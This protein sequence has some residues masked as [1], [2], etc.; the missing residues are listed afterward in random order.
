MNPETLTILVLAGVGF[1][2]L[3]QHYLPFEAISRYLWCSSNGKPNE[4]PP[5]SSES[6]ATDEPIAQNGNPVSST[7]V[8][9]PDL[10]LSPPV[11]RSEP[12]YG[13]TVPQAKICA[14]DLTDL[15]SQQEEEI[16][17]GPCSAPPSSNEHRT[18]VPLSSRVSP[19]VLDDE[20]GLLVQSL[21]SFSHTPFRGTSETPSPIPT[22]P[23]PHA[24]FNSSITDLVPIARQLHPIILNADR[25]G[26][27]SVTNV[28]PALNLKP[29]TV[30]NAPLGHAPPVA[31]PIPLVSPQA[32]NSLPDDRAV[33]PWINFPS[34]S[35]ESTL[36][37][38]TPVVERPFA[39][40]PSGGRSA[41][42]GPNFSSYGTSL[43]QPS[44]FRM[45]GRTHGGTPTSFLLHSVRLAASASS[46][47]G[48]SGSP[49]L[50]AP[51]PQSIPVAVTT[52]RDN[53]SAIC[54]GNE[55]GPQNGPGSASMLNGSMTADIA[56]LQCSVHEGTQLLQS[57]SKPNRLNPTA[58]TPRLV[59][60]D[61]DDTL[62]RRF[63]SSLDGTRFCS[64]L[65]IK[66]REALFFDSIFFREFCQMCSAHGHQLRI[67]SHTDGCET[68]P[69]ATPP[70][71][72]VSVILDGALHSKRSY[73]VSESHIACWPSHHGKNPHIEQFLQCTERS[74][75]G[76]FDLEQ[77]ILIDDH[78]QNV[79]KARAAGYHGFLVEKGQG[80]DRYWFSHQW[81]LSRL[82]GFE[83]RDALPPRPSVRSPEE[84]SSGATAAATSQQG[85]RTSPGWF[86]PSPVRERSPWIGSTPKLQSTAAILQLTSPPSGVAAG[87]QTVPR[88]R[89]LG[90]SPLEMRNIVNAPLGIPSPTLI[91]ADSPAVKR[92]MS[93]ASS[94]SA[95]PGSIRR[96]PA[97]VPV[98]EPTANAQPQ[99][100]ASSLAAPAPR[101]VKITSPKPTPNQSPAEPS[102]MGAAPTF[103][104][105]VG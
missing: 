48:V 92:A 32:G 83:L 4:Q 16:V 80:F 44:P 3:Q 36:D 10:C 98:P 22:A 70:W 46:P 102:L 6:F 67:A 64:D 52:L 18:V 69:A 78:P 8:E 96:E 105:T 68:G 74:G 87:P 41:S 24:W 90:V 101:R 50:R 43:A 103:K 2:H 15:S 60:F 57:I 27:L 11:P 71:S 59:I 17:E 47:T 19:P 88:Y 66:E 62:I 20:E 33:S 42:H 63:L 82:L 29:Q 12:A 39:S 81:T 86:Q 65:S 25:G 75:E 9:E 84:S 34:F 99:G 53:K 85:D 45:E 104:R 5:C 97:L 79:A 94:P 95:P 73:L 31:L 77:V 56:A 89:S 91:H 21:R 13:N 23:T 28:P 93:A 38:R 49:Q 58:V 51:T 72:Q 1:R 61:L 14:A 54:N 100:G 40:T 55:V 37:R 7:P 35:Q 76:R 26:P 30:M